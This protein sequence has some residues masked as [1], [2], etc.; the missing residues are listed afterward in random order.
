MARFVALMGVRPHQRI[1]DLGGVATL[2]RFVDIPLDIT[3]V[4]LDAADLRRRQ[5]GPHRFTYL[6]GNATDLMGLADDSFDIVFS[7]SCIEHVGPREKQ[8]AFSREVRRLAQSY[9]VQTPAPSFPIEAHTGLPFWWWWP[10]S[11]RRHITLRWRRKDPNYAAFIEETR[12]LSAGQLSAL[13]PD[14]AIY[15]E[16]VAGFTKSLAAWKLQP[17]HDGALR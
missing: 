9:F 3:I 12:S 17:G 11:L 10:S 15:K 2:W 13:F 16:R 1:L 8:D 5:D 14:A 4:N 6:L 7:N